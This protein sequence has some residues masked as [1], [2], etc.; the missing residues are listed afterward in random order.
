MGNCKTKEQFHLL[1]VFQFEK[2][3]K[4]N[5]KCE[6]LTRKW[7]TQCNTTT[8]AGIKYE[9]TC[10]RSV[11]FTTHN[12][13][14]HN[15]NQLFTYNWFKKILLFSSFFCYKIISLYFNWIGVVVS[16]TRLTIE[17]TCDLLT[18]KSYLL[19]SLWNRYCDKNNVWTS[20]NLWSNYKNIS[21]SLPC[22]PIVG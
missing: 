12:C 7:L 6:W 3:T 2:N 8:Y 13:S 5:L 1:I 21:Q 9:L 14:Y 4:K 10:F 19:N 18:C 15:N 22:N 16:K 20:K 17:L 11:W